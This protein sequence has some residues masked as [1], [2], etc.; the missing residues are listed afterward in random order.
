MSESVVIIAEGLSSSF[1]TFMTGC[2]SLQR[3]RDEEVSLRV[4][5]HNAKLL[6]R[7]DGRQDMNST[8][9]LRL[10]Y[11]GTSSRCTRGLRGPGLLLFSM[12]LETKV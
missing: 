1:S 9:P 11:E 6:R 7:H 5:L 10:G 12:P 2:V 4:E 3:A 8:L